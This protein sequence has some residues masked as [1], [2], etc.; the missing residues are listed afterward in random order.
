[1]SMRHRE[2]VSEHVISASEGPPLD[3]DANAIAV[4][5]DNDG[6]TLKPLDDFEDSV[7][8]SLVGGYRGF[9]PDDLSTLL[10]F[11]Q[12]NPAMRS[13]ALLAALTRSKC[14]L[15]C[16]PTDA[17]CDTVVPVNAADLALMVD[18]CMRRLR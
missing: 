5:A 8:G 9:A 6:F 1:M 3:T 16:V 4:G 2:P 17:K 13:S 11:I 12:D 15:D 7:W 14:V 18:A 10:D